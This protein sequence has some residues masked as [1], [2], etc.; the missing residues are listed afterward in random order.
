MDGQPRSFVPAVV[1]GQRFARQVCS[2][3]VTPGSSRFCMRATGAGGL[4]SPLRSQTMKPLLRVV[5]KLGPLVCSFLT[6]M[7][8][9]TYGQTDVR[10]EIDLDVISAPQAG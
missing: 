2:L 3:V 10:G 9:T 7:P 1:A 6:L 5:K 4:A 8:V